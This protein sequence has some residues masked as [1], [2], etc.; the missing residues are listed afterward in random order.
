MHMST[1]LA[2]MVWLQHKTSVAYA[3]QMQWCWLQKSALM[4]WPSLDVVATNFKTLPVALTFTCLLGNMLNR[5]LEKQTLRPNIQ[6]HTQHTPDVLLIS[7]VQ[8]CS[9]FAVRVNISELFQTWLWHLLHSS[10]IFQHDTQLSIIT[11]LL[12][13]YWLIMPHTC[14]KCCLSYIYNEQGTVSCAMEQT[15]HSCLCEWCLDS[16]TQKPL[17]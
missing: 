12:K 4:M 6:W 13:S 3:Y 14:K 17:V 5:H 10:A 11:W 16:P 15:F 1:V 7:V 8:L 2:L 9:L